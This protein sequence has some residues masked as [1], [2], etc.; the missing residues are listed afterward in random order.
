MG[1]GM[2]SLDGRKAFVTGAGGG[3]GSAIA[4]ALATQGAAV[5]LTD[6]DEAKAAAKASEIGER[7]PGRTLIPLAMDVTSEESVR[8][9]FAVAK[10]RLGLVDV[11]VNVAGIAKIRPLHEMSFGEGREMLAIH[12]DGTFLGTRYA[13][14]DMLEQGWGRVICVSSIVADTGVAYE[15]HYGAA[16]GGING[17]IRSVAREVAPKGVTVNAIAPG[18]FDTPL[19][20][21]IPA[22]EYR[23]LTENIAVGRFGKPEEVGALAA[24][25][26][27]DEAAYI[28]GEVIRPHGGFSY[29]RADLDAAPD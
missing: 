28:T 20:D 16:K 23:L 3:L 7:L 26:G 12:L 21:M 8:D 4:E 17:L 18:Y 10:Q 13:L 6:L 22:E 15:A 24:Y 29:G 11:M 19:S 5:V 27:S 25:L 14:P 2:F 1:I 9:A